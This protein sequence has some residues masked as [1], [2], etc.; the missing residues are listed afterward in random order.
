MWRTLN[1]VPAPSHC[2]EPRR[3]PDTP[4]FLLQEPASVTRDQLG[5]GAR[6]CHLQLQEP[7]TLHRLTKGATVGGRRLRTLTVHAVG[8]VLER[9]H[10][11]GG[12]GAGVGAHAEVGAGHGGLPG[13]GVAGVDHGGVVHAASVLPRQRLDLLLQVLRL[14]LSTNIHEDA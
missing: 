2:S 12:V 7:A 6:C 5:L 4:H 1:T 13:R 14:Q 3:L 8:G 11:R 10:G 9:V